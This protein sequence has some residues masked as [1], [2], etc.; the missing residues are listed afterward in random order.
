MKKVW[1]LLLQNTELLKQNCKRTELTKGVQIEKKETNLLVVLPFEPKIH[2][3]VS[4]L[5]FDPAGLE[6][7][8]VRTVF[9]R[10]IP[11]EEG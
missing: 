10:P 7:V 8:L 3:P 2:V 9:E 4:S 5:Q 6:I 1:A 11:P